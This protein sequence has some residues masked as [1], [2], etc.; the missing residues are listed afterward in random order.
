MGV[1]D[2]ADGRRGARHRGRG[3]EPLRAER[4]G[5]VAERSVARDERQSH[6]TWRTAEGGDK[7]LRV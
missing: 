1:T 3:P 2:I 7:V 6:V 5:P 4:G